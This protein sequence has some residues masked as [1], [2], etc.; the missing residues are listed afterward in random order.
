MR[1]MVYHGLGK[2]AWE[3]V[4]DPELTDEGDAIVRVDTTTSA[5][6]TRPAGALASSAGPARWP[7]LGR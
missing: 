4:P 6:S 2:V 1:A 7:S 3:D 5:G